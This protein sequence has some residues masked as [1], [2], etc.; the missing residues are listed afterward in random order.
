MLSPSLSVSP[1]T[2]SLLPKPS[3]VLVIGGRDLEL[4]PQTNSLWTINQIKTMGQFEQLRREWAHPDDPIPAPDVVVVLGPYAEDSFFI[5]PFHYDYEPE[6]EAATHIAESVG[7]LLNHGTRNTIIATRDARLNRE[8][9]AEMSLQEL[10]AGSETIDILNPDT[11]PHAE[12]SLLLGLLDQVK[13][14]NGF[15]QTSRERRL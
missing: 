11:A 13:F 5:P 6:D 15:P 7:A 10:F 1:P 12:G 3:T 4:D 2:Q 14:A 9:D 8:I